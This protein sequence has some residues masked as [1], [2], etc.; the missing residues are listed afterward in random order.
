MNALSPLNFRDHPTRTDWAASIAAALPAL[1]PT[2]ADLEL[3]RGMALGNPPLDAQRAIELLRPCRRDD[4]KVSL[5]GQQAM[6][7]ALERM[8]LPEP[9]AAHVAPRK[10]RSDSPVDQLRACADEGLSKA[11]TARKLG[12]TP[13]SVGE[14]ARRYGIAFKP[15]EKGGD[16]RR[17]LPQSEAAA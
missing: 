11:Q 10:R 6:L 13:A 9:A 8:A 14:C 15:G 1:R 3:F 12:L 7:A 2:T 16:V 17:K 5:D 4:G